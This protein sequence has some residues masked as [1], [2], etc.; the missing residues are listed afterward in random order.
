MRDADLTFPNPFADPKAPKAQ[1]R[2]FRARVF[3][4][5][6]Q[7]YISQAEG[8]FCG[9]RMSATGQLLKRADYKPGRELTEAELRQRM[10]MVQRVAAELNAFKFAGGPP[11]VA[12][13]IFRRPR[14]Y[15]KSAR[16]SDSH[17]DRM[18]RGSI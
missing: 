14:A 7:I 15:G 17:G 2:N 9:V 10:E 11:V 6:D 5:P 1:L 18:Q 12:V 4:P 3:F 8:I 16:R 13:E